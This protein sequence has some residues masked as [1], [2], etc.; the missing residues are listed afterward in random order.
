MNESIISA[1]LLQMV[2]WCRQ[3][4][5]HFVHA[6]HSSNTVSG[7]QTQVKAQDSGSTFSSG[8]PGL[9]HRHYF[10][11]YSK[12]KHLKKDV[13]HISSCVWG[14]ICNC[15]VSPQYNSTFRIQL[16]FSGF[17]FKRWSRARILST[18]WIGTTPIR[19]TLFLPLFQWNYRSIFLFF[20]KPFINVSSLG[21]KTH[22]NHKK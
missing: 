10:R 20:I 5:G 3:V 7:G 21:G 18:Y 6:L 17:C 1:D 14:L 16:I 9:L 2:T 8:S 19:Y 13:G 22:H 11:N 15:I 4:S 12:T